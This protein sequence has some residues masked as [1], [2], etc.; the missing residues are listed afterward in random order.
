MKR[1]LKVLTGH[2]TAI[3]SL[4]RKLREISAPKKKGLRK[5]IGRGLA[6]DVT[7]YYPGEAGGEIELMPEQQVDDD[8]LN[9]FIEPEQ[10]P[11]FQDEIDILS[12][13]QMER[14]VMMEQIRMVEVDSM[15]MYKDFNLRIDDTQKLDINDSDELEDVSSEDS[16][17]SDDDKD[18]E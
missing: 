11:E 3:D 7:S 13:G 15:P 14:D 12:E 9:D 18:A 8:G 10:P 17:V 5:S 16:E 6:D 1:L 2:S 4:E